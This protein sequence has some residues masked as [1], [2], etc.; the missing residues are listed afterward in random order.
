MNSLLSETEYE[1]GFLKRDSSTVE[2]TL[3]RIF[4]QE[5]ALLSKSAELEAQQKS[6]EASMMALFY[7]WAADESTRLTWE[8]SRVQE[9][10][11]KQAI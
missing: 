7:S 3:D 1:S 6:A 8:S 2:A 4:A 11:T 5:S 10:C 9:D